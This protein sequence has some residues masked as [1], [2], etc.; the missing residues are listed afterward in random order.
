[1]QDPYSVL[2]VNPGATK[3]E[4][5]KAFKKRAMET[6]PDRGGNEEE[7][8]KVNEAYERIKNPHKHQSNP[9]GG[10]SWSFSTEDLDDIT[11]GGFQF[12]RGRNI[13]DL[14]DDFFSFH[15]GARSPFKNQSVT[16]QVTLEITLRDCI[17][18]GHKQINISTRSGSQM[19]EIH[20]PQG[21]ENG[22][23]I[24]YDGIGP[25]NSNLRI[26]F[27]IQEHP[28]WKRSG[29][30]LIYIMDVSFWDCITGIRKQFGHLDGR[31]LTVNIP[32][33]CDAGTK[34]RL[35]G[36]GIKNSRQTGDLY[37]IVK[38]TIPDNIPEELMMAIK[39]HTGKY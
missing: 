31:Q 38:A 29:Q 8:K 28:S 14:F 39:K 30:D 22:Q 2:G 15:G 25:N 19:C 21:V 32:A 33:N 20:I 7:F 34:L 13:N 24:R 17:I 10:G 37:V 23:T 16:T 1:M 6:H 12:K 26:K 9:F 3:D 11:P 27:K 4:V 5:K 35:G 18:G 36:Q